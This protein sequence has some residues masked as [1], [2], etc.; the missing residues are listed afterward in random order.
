MIGPAPCLICVTFLFPSLYLTLTK[1]RPEILPFVIKDYP[2][3]SIIRPKSNVKNT[4]GL[5]K[6]PAPVGAHAPRPN[7]DPK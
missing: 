5:S 3:P 7:G 2:V 6:L 4:A 1:T